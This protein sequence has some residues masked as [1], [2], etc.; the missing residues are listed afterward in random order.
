MNSDRRSVPEPELYRVSEVARILRVSKDT[1]YRMV[2]R[3]EL[4]HRIVA[5]MTRIPVA[6]VRR[7]LDEDS[8]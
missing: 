1:V 4:P 5:G 6:A 3:G 2:H 8:N 7:Q